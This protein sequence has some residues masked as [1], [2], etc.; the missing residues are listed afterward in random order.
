VAR[1][2]ASA[3]EQHP[4]PTIRHRIHHAYLP[5]QTSLDLMREYRIPALATIPFLTNLGESFVT[6]LGKERADRIM[7]LKSYLEAG[8]PVALSSDAPVT[9]FNPWTGMYSAVTRK[10]VYGR[11]LGP[12]ERIS[13]EEALR[14]Y[15]S[16]AAWVT[17]EDGIKGSI[18]PGMLAD[19]AILDRDVLTVPEEEIKETRSVMTIVGGDV[20]HDRMT[21]G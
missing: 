14:L 20:T 18:T 17:F 19:V 15:T 3:Y 7:P 13:R 4:N 6:S 16:A 11:E 8:V 9:T 5:T 12:D 10:T 21:A 2:Y 1:A